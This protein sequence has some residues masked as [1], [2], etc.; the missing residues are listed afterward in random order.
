MGNRFFTLTGYHPVIKAHGIIAAIAFLFIIPAAIFIMRFGG[1]RPALARR[2]HIWL[3][4]L[5]LLLSTVVLI[6]GVFAVGPV[7]ALT[8]PHH[9]IGVAI[10]TLIWVQLIGGCLVHRRQRVHKP[11]HV[12]LTAML[13]HWL[14]RAIALLGI[15]QVALGLTLYGSPLILFILYALMV[16]VLLVTYFILEWLHERRRAEY[17]SQHS[18]YVDETVVRPAEK[19]HSGLGKL[20]AAGAAGAGLTALFRRRSSGRRPPESIADGT[21]SGTSYMYDEKES[22]APR[23][24]WG[25]R[26]LQVG[27]IGGGLAAAKH[28]FS[29]N[30]RVQDNDSDIGPYRPP[31]GGNQSITTDSLSRV[32]EGRASN[33]TTP[34]RQ[35]Q[36]Y[37]RPSHPLAQ[38]PMTPGSGRRDS[39]DT[40]SYYSYMSGSPS[41]R[42]RHQTFRDAIAAGGTVFAVRQLFKNRRQKKEDRRAEN[43]RKQNIE[44][45]RIQRMDS[46]NRYTGDGVLPPRRQRHN[47]INSQTA[48]DVSSVIDGSV[49]HAGLGSAA[50]IAGAGAGLAAASA[51][52]DRDRVRPPG[53][54]PVISPPGP[55]SALPPP[56]QSQIPPPPPP[57]GQDFQSSGSELYTTASGR[58]RHRHHVQPNVAVPVAAGTGLA[59]AAAAA[60]SSRRRHSGQHTD[61]IESPPVS[62]KVKMHNDGRHVTLRRLTE[63]EAAAQREARRRERRAS[64][65]R[66][67]R[68]SSFGSPS[69]SEPLGHAQSLA[70]D[71][72]WRQTEALEA[73]QSA[74]NAAAA[75][76]SAQLSVLP[77]S[78]AGGSRHPTPTPPAGTHHGID[79]QTGLAYTAPPIPPV[80]ASTSNLGPT[81]SAITSPGT[82]TSGATGATEYANNRRRRRAERAQ[83]RLAREGRAGG[84]STVEFT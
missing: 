71:D 13:H 79:P 26:L 82:E 35:S 6:L 15:A 36:G 63:E 16:F 52:A 41:R 66:R 14:G 22:E 17:Q 11:M 34:M 76:S 8:N 28:V 2:I 65:S 78:T 20:A 18:S 45:E 57:H 80:P 50:P 77:A 9:G 12:P 31:L 58:Q 43:L 47:R 54:D 25:H 23:K 39:D 32:E 83:A 75:T 10:Y 49:Q 67:R 64:A 19:R 61:S 21:E 74:E 60:E 30:K 44:Q 84:G 33:P 37:V 69:G 29:R 48:S 1:R 59:A 5:T 73:R 70:P 72:R 27:A 38:P 24:G 68:N 55:A 62:L 81:S 42:G 4:I 3:Q 56:V 53:T 7:R 46:T 51:L 40:Y